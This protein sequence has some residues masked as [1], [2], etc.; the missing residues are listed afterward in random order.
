MAALP[1]LVQLLLLICVNHS[2]SLKFIEYR[3]GT[4]GS[5][6]I[7][8]APHGGSLKNVSIP[9]R[10]YGCW[11]LDEKCIY[12]YNCSGYGVK[13]KN[14]KTVTV[15]DMNTKQISVILR[16]KIQTLTGKAPHLIINNLHR[17]KMD[18][19]REKEQATF[20]DPIAG[21]AWEDFQRYI[22]N[23]RKAI[24]GPGVLFDIHGKRRE[25]IELGYLL[26]G[27]TLDNTTAKINPGDTSI[28]SLAERYYRR[29]RFD[30][31][32]RGKKSFGAF[33][34]NFGYETI[35]SPAFPGPGGAKF[36]RGGYITQRYG[37]H[38]GGKV[39]AIQIESPA[40]LRSTN[41][42]PGYSADLAKAIIEFVDKY[43]QV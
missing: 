41:V 8:T 3:P 6:I 22:E 1:V 29:I 26:R 30:E 14:C 40:S 24:G 15:S 11:T 12:R 34:Q 17:S 38:N 36:Y 16:Q 33:I 42:Y 21:K 32:L 27:P 25:R 23:A 20:G 9:D 35:P 31:I 43:Y 19:N 28:K 4:G 5:K 37:S 39:D 18:P 10:G 13:S 7:I 2:L